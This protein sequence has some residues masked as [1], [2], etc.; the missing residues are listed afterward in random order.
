[1]RI[2]GSIHLPVLFDGDARVGD[3]EACTSSIRGAISVDC[4]IRLPVASPLRNARHQFSL[5]TATP[6]N[7]PAVPA[8]PTGVPSYEDV[9]W[10]DDTSF[11]WDVRQV[12]ETT[13]VEGFTT[14]AGE[15]AAV[16]P[17]PQDR[18]LV[19][20]LPT[21]RFDSEQGAVVEVAR[22]LM[23]WVPGSPVSCKLVNR[24]KEKVAVEGSR[25]IARMVALSVRDK[26]AFDSLF[27]TA[28]SAAD[29]PLA[30]REPRA[31]SPSPPDGESIP[32][33]RVED[34]NL[35]ALGTLKKQQ[36]VNVLAAFIENGLFPIDQKASAGL[37]QRWKSP[38]KTVIRRPF[39]MRMNKSALG[40][41]LGVFSWL[42]D[43]L[44]ASGTWKEH[45][46]TLTLVLNRL[47]AAGLSVT[48]AKCI[49]GAA[50]QE[51]LGMIIDSTGLYTA[52]SRLDAIARMP[53]PHT[54]EELRTFLGLTGYLCQFV[55][56]YGLTAASLTNIIL[57]NKAFASKRAR[58]LPIPWSAAEEGAFQSLRETLASPKVLAFPYLERPFELHTDASTLGVGASLMQTVDGVTRAVAFASHRFSQTDARRGPTER[59]CMAVLWAVDH[60]RPYLAG[61]R[62]ALRLMEYDLELEWKAGV[63]HV[64]PD[65][66]SRLPVANPVERGRRRRFV[67]G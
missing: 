3:V 23:W 53:R 8:V 4:T 54:V 46:A 47:L 41:L 22:A 59:E 60:F 10:E 32:R 29:P 16:G 35:G 6:D 67:S 64:V 44:I 5:L 26:P 52:P 43:I 58:K 17:Q 21:K 20:V 37:H 61:R 45:L 34:A 14:R 25:V 15:V 48:F 27:D 63:E 65:A 12:P 56:N 31:P 36:L 51:F 2:L 50:S 19:M 66:L 28:P 40:H 42:D 18:Q 24:G 57:R 9:V 1:M 11:E 7:A 55:P 13:G 30:P 39:E 62:W 38:R 33:V 49:F